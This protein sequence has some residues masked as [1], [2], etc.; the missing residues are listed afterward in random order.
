[1][2][3]VGLV[4][5]EVGIGMWGSPHSSVQALLAFLLQGIATYVLDAFLTETLL[6][7]IV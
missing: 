3:S 6:N 4:C 2:L 5:S 1:M 7:A